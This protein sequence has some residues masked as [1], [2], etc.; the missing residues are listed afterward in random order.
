MVDCNLCDEI[1]PFLL[2]AAFGQNVFIMATKN[3]AE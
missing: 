3:K 2:Q 1:N